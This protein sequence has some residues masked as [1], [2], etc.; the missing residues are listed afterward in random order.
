M[1]RLVVAVEGQTEEAFVKEV[2]GPHLA[3]RQVFTAPMIVATRRDPRTGAK[4][5]GG[6]RRWAKWRND[7]DKVLR[8]DASPQ[9]RVTT[10][11]D[12][13]ALPSDF[14]GADEHGELPDTVRRASLLEAAMADVFGD[15]RLVPYLQRHEFEALVF[16]GLEQLHFL[17]DPVNSSGVVA[18][19][20]E[21]AGIPP[22]DVNDNEHTAPS[23]RLIKHLG[24]DYD[25][26][27]LGPLVTIAAGLP[28]IRAAC[29]RFDAWVTKLESL[30]SAPAP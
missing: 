25:K 16:A 21:V 12:L 14:P 1:I 6:G 23:K 5:K 27:T 20:A 29:P 15:W 18:L 26:V 3:A 8:T 28:A 9:L 7:I 11:F 19:R 2:L 13:Y 22:E 4:S 17:L 10:L 30:A 24:S